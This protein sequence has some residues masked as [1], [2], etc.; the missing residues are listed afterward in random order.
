ME[1]KEYFD[2]A[3]KII[4]ARQK[5]LLEISGAISLG[6]ALNPDAKEG[7]N[8]YAIVVNMKAIDNIA[9]LEKTL[10]EMPIIYQLINID[11]NDIQTVKPDTEKEKVLKGGIQIALDSGASST[12]GGIVKGIG[13]NKYYGIT[14][15][16][17]VD[18][19]ANN[20][21]Y[22]PEKKVQCTCCKGDCCVEGRVGES[23]K[24]TEKSDNTKDAALIELDEGIE[25]CNEIK[26]IGTIQGSKVL[27][28]HQLLNLRVQ[29]RGRSTLLTK[30]VISQILYDPVKTDKFQCSVKAIDGTTFANQGD[31]G[32]LVL[33]EECE[34]VA[35]LW[36]MNN[37]NSEGICT[38]IGEVIDFLQIEFITGEF[39]AKGLREKKQIASNIYFSSVGRRKLFL[40][41]ID[42]HSREVLRLVN[43]CRPVTIVWQRLNGPLYVDSII[44]YYKSGNRITLSSLNLEQTINLLEAMGEV[45]FEYGSFDLRTDLLRY[46]NDVYDEFKQ[47][48]QIDI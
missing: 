15:S 23:G 29:K 14:N 47:H 20:V 28:P 17:C 9:T 26:D 13:D 21:V 3:R 19:G 18:Y 2:C 34:V 30:G 16:H 11:Q 45:L 41:L 10:D 6:I 44:S 39:K 27:E 4:I 12:L 25:W 48:I 38:P 7:G 33:N 31:S 5:E 42:R 24:I 1:N 37:L 35:L 36:A 22:H 40:E 43:H 46:S 32:S 8:P